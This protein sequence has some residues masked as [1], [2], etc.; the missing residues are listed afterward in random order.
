MLNLVKH[1]GGFLRESKEEKVDYT[2]IPT[3]VLTALA[4][5]YTDGAKKHGR[6]NWKKAES[7]ETFE[8]SMFRHLIGIINRD[9]SEDHHSSLEWNSMC[10]KWHLLH[11]KK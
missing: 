7:V 3:D 2:L 1:K 5:H 9:K 6:D 10:H 4:K 8:Q 11:G